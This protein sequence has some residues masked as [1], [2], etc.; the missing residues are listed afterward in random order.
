MWLLMSPKSSY[1]ILDKHTIV[2]VLCMKWTSHRISFLG[3]EIAMKDALLQNKSTIVLHSAICIAAN[4]IYGSFTFYVD[5]CYRSWMYVWVAWQ[6]SYKK[7]Q[8]SALREYLRSLPVFIL[9]V[10]FCGVRVAH[11]FSVLCCPIMCLYLLISVSW[12]ALWF[13]HYNGVRFVFTSSCL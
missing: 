9:L 5:V 2:D 13:P 11:L 4:V 6:V 12:S 3:C 7:Q 1:E 10:F 8:L